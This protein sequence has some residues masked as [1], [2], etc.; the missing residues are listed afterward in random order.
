M[1]WHVLCNYCFYV[2]VILQPKRNSCA[3]FKETVPYLI[4]TWTGTVIAQ[5][6]LGPFSSLLREF[7]QHSRR[8]FSMTQVMVY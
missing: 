6:G 4:R 3:V 7:M 5:L 8:M 2:P 1:T